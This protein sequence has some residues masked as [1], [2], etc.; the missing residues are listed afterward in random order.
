MGIDP[1]IPVGTSGP[2]LDDQPL[3]NYRKTYLEITNDLEEAKKDNDHARMAEPEKQKETFSVEIEKATALGGRKREMSDSER[4]R[5]NVSNAVTR[6]IDSV[7]S[8]HERLGKHLGN[9]INSGSVFSYDPE[10]DP[11]WLV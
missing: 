7:A 5:K 8:E 4:V 11:Q 10:R 9:S 6:A 3:R 1:R 2:V